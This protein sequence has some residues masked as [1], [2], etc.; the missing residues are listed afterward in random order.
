MEKGP[1]SY[2]GLGQFGNESSYISRGGSGVDPLSY[3]AG[4]ALDKLTGGS[5]MGKKMMGAAK[6][7][8][9]MSGLTQ[10]TIQGGLAPYNPTYG[11]AAPK[12]SI[13]PNTFTS[14]NGLDKQYP[15]YDFSSNNTQPGFQHTN[16]ALSY[17]DNHSQGAK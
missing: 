13:D 6:P 5:D 10:P 9:P 17:W 1:F 2:V 14:I 11:L 7:P 4:Y 16:S 12:S 3:M 15:T 8:A